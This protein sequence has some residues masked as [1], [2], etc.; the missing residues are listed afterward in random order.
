MEMKQK[1]PC[2]NIELVFDKQNKAKHPDTPSDSEYCTLSGKTIH[3]GKDWYVVEGSVSAHCCFEYTIMQ[4]NEI[5]AEVLS[6]DIQIAHTMA[7][8]KI[9]KDALEKIAAILLK[10]AKGE[11]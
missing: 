11:G 7:S 8:A 9:T 10:A 5:L 1:C 4:G 6:N 3:A 2:C